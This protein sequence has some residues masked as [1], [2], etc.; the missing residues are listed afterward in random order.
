MAVAKEWALNTK[1]ARTTSFTNHVAKCCAVRASSSGRF[2][3]FKRLAVQLR[4]A[5]FLDLVYFT[6]VTLSGFTYHVEGER[7]GL[8]VDHDM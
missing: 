3:Q 2:L 4:H 8:L 5:R 6:I 1:E 7:E